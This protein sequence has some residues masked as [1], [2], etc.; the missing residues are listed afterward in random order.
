MSNPKSKNLPETLS[1]YLVI[2]VIY[3]VDIFFFQS[4]RTVLADAFFSRCLGLA[5]TFGYIWVTRSSVSLVGISPKGKKFTAGLVYGVV[6]SVIPIILVMLGECAF[7]ALTDASAISLRFATPNLIYIRN[8]EN[9]TAGAAIAIYVLTTLV[10]SVFKEFFFRGMLL[11]RFK[12]SMD[13]NQANVLQAVLYMF[14][15]IPLLL[16]N[17]ITHAYDDTTLSLGIYIIMFYIIHE[18]LAGIKWGL[19]TRVTGATYVATVDHFLYVFI[20]NS[21]FI[22]SR[23]VTWSFMAHMLMIQIISFVLVLFYYKK[24]MKKLEEKRAQEKEE[25]DKKIKQRIEQRKERER[26][27]IVDSK[28]REINEISPEQYKDIVQETNDK[29]HRHHTSSS[30]QK[31]NEV[32]S[33]FNEDLIEQVSTAD[34]DKI[35]ND[36]IQ[37]ELNASHHHHSHNHGVSPFDVIARLEDYSSSD[38]VRKKTEEYSDSPDHEQKNTKHSHHHDTAAHGSRLTHEQLDKANADK[39]GSFSEHDVDQFLNNFKTNMEKQSFSQYHHHRHNSKENLERI[40]NLTQNLDIDKFLEDFQNDGNIEQSFEY[41]S[42]SHHHHEHSHHRDEEDVVSMS[43]V[44]TEEFFDEYQKAVE[45]K[46]EKKKQ[47]FI[48]RMRELGKIDDSEYNDLL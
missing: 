30:R 33:A 44:S 22:T 38:D 3:C 19:L 31:Q 14:M 46:K 13:F 15:T 37:Q 10:G 45:E 1:M 39:I 27:N 9:L 32:N 5:L 11:K 42:S 23:Y 28:I 35:L 41:H 29:R 12:K 17:L 47:K 40:K 4:D 26:N 24:N 7:Y 48:Q 36:F 34:A 6:F 25:N 21:V 18:T 20:S 43:E 8:S 2:L 16:R